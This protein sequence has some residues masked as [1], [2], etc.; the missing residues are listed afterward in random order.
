M[1]K[2]AEQLSSARAA[3]LELFSMSL[4]QLALPTA[5][6]TNAYVL[7][8]LIGLQTELLSCATAP[9]VIEAGLLRLEIILHSTLILNAHVL[10]S[11]L[12]MQ[13]FRTAHAASNR[14]S[15]KF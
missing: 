4:H 9:G 11:S 12:I 14:H 6:V 15:A 2:A 3:V 1:S 10:T 5:T 13:A 8:Q 7:M